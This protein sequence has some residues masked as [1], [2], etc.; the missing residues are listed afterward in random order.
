MYR[1]CGDMTDPVREI[2]TQVVACAHELCYLRTQQLSLS[3]CAAHVM[4]CVTFGVPIR[5]V[6]FQF[7]ALVDHLDS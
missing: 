2:S 7:H 4:S 1:R 6:L 5:G 3:V